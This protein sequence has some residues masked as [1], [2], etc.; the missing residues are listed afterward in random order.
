M[1][2][3][4]FPFSALAGGYLPTSQITNQITRLNS[5]FAGS[6]YSFKLVSTTRTLNADWFNKAGPGSAQQTAMKRSLRVGGAAAL[7]LYSVGFVSGSGVGLLGY[8]TFPWSYSGN[9]RD[10]G[11]VFLYSS[12]PGGTT[13]NYNLGRTLTH[14]IGRKYHSSSIS[15]SF[16]IGHKS[17]LT[18]IVLVTRLDW[19]GLYHTFQGG[20]SGSGDYVSD[21]P[22]EASPATGCPSCRNTCTSAGSDP[23]HN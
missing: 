1:H 11:I 20:C 15:S 6:G 18:R 12:V 5:D 3:L 4:D 23:I 17:V 7:N 16:P 9:P 21:T 8:A 22:A 14:E 10:D 19:V 2:L 13:A